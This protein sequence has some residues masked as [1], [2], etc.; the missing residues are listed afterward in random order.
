[1]R[2][3][4]YNKNKSHKKQHIPSK[5]KRTPGFQVPPG[6]NPILV[7]QEAKLEYGYRAKLNVLLQ[8]A[9]DACLLSTKNVRGLG[10]ASAQALR[11]EFRKMMN[12]ISE[13]LVEDSKDDPD[14]VWSRDKV[15]KALV[16]IEGP[17]NAKE[18]DARF[19]WTRKV[20]L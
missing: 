3:N 2:K 4:K 10:P 19:E 9:E 18:W 14:I 13:L 20:K 6:Y 11:Q 15:D 12:T 7:A 16:E 1:M 5:H 17:E 8:M